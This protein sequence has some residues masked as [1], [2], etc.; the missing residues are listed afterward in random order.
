MRCPKV[1]KSSTSSPAQKSA[2]CIPLSSFGGSQ[3]EA[4]GHFS[5][6]ND[7]QSYQPYLES[8]FRG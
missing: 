7:Y 4:A 2:M 6:L 3:E 1:I 5:Q 8:L